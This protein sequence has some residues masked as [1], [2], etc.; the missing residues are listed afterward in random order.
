MVESTEYIFWNHTINNNIDVDGTVRE[1]TE[2]NNMKNDR[3]YKPNMEQ[4]GGYFM[5]HKISN[6]T[7]YNNVIKRAGNLNYETG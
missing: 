4:I 1:E 6:S 3:Q 5:V 2:W 7:E